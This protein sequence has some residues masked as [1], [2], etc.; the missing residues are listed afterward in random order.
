LVPDGERKV[1]RSIGS[2]A[3]VQ[4][5]RDYIAARG[6]TVTQFGIQFQTSDRTVR[7]FL[8]SGLLRRGN[9]E[10]MAAYIGVTVEQLLA[11]KL[12]PSITRPARR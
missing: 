11:G 10:A 4:A 12:P 7:N 8:K 6:L 1:Q 9:F 2:S 5:V 3:A